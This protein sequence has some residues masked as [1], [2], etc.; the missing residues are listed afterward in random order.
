MSNIFDLF[1]DLLNGCFVFADI[2]FLICCSCF[3]ALF[4]SLILFLVRGKF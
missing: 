3:V 2:Y 4:S 1:F